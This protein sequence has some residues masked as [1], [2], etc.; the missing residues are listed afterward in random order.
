MTDFFRQIV[1]QVNDRRSEVVDL[2][3]DLIRFP[4][5]NPPGEAYTPCAEYLGRRMARSGFDVRYIRAND[6]PGDSDRYPRT[7]IVARREGSRPGPVVHFNSHIDVVDT[8]E[9]WSV[10][11]FAAVVRDLSGPR[12]RGT[13]A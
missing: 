1:D 9:G 3:C 4:T 10:D 13:S 11:P 12:K 2:T 8:G 6:T 7:N 5:V